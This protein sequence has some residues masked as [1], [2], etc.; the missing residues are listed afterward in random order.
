[1]KEL[2]VPVILGTVA[3][4]LLGF[5]CVVSGVRARKGV[6]N[7]TVSRNVKVPYE[8]LP[9]RERVRT[10]NALLVLGVVLLL[11]APFSVLPEAAVVV[12]FLAA[13]CSF[14]SYAVIQMGL[15]RA[16]QEIVRGKVS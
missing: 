6:G 4:A 5:A 15:R 12:L 3:Y 14:I 13:L 11:C 2:V 7:Y 9:Q 16:A 10:G 1:L 8:E